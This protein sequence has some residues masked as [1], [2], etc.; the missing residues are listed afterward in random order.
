MNDRF[1]FRI[2]AWLWMHK[3]KPFTILNKVSSD[4]NRLSL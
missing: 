1:S 3:S 2:F 4:I